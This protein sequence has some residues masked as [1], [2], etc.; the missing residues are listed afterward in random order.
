MQLIM[1]GNNTEG[2]RYGT[3]ETSEKYYLRWKEDNKADDEV[4]IMVQSMIIDDDYPLD[5]ELIGLCNKKRFLEIIHDFIVFDS[6]IKKL[7]RKN[8]YLHLKW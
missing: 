3:I 5:K 8:Q 2:L 1:A 6:G 4:S 7:C